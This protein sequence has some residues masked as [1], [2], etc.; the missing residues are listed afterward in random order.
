MLKLNV[1]IT[2]SFLVLAIV[3]ETVLG[4]ALPDADFIFDH[5]TVVPMNKEVVIPD[6]SVVVRDG[7]IVAIVEGPASRLYRSAIH[8]DG[9]GKFLMPGLS[10]MHVHLRMPPQ[11]FFDLNLAAGVTT[12]FNMGTG[13]GGGK[14]DHLALRAKVAAGAID[15]PRY[16]VSGPQ[17]ESDNVKSL[18]DVSKTLH[19]AS[20]R[21]YDAIKIHGD[22][23]HEIYDALINGAREK[24]FRIRG[25]AQHMMP[26]AQTLRMDCVE[27]IE[28]LL[29]L[30]RDKTFGEEAKFGSEEKGNINNFL[31][32]YYHNISR[33]A[34][35]RYRAAI[36]KDRADSGV[37]WDPTLIIYSMIPIYVSDD[38]FAALAHDPRL[39]YL[40]ESVQRESLDKDK[41]EYRAGLV[42]VFS[43]FLRHVGD[44]S[45][46]KDH[47][48]KNI[49]LLLNLIK[50]LHDQGV[51]LLVGSDAF[52]ALVPGFAP[53]QEMQL[54]VEAGLTP[55]QVLQ[56]ATVNSARYLGEYD[57]AGTV[58]VGKRADFILLE[59][60]PLDNI[61]N[62]ADVR[63]VFTH[64]RWHSPEDL[65]MRLSRVE[66]D[67]S[68]DN[69]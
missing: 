34:D 61:K 2:F 51:P 3:P 32:A 65:K 29:Y 28:E 58:E 5:V 47:F 9:R 45:S 59:K 33:L 21:H 36:V 4:E 62:A 11:D 13:D 17:L 35:P 1:V 49:K 40:P 42:P 60:N 20:E 50:E 63:G 7:I 54:L 22:F 38:S 57:R 64:G 26:L 48:D 18:Q 12:V 56:A 31:T 44:Q 52:G 14:I 25:H 55:F 27:H 15:G 67:S 24:G 23:S 69:K 41:N 8:I 39:K 19:E 43:S 37:Y 16:L 53:H 6:K 10:D 68:K 46:L 66:R 30:S